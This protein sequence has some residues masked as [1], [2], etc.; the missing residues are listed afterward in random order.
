MIEKYCR[1]EHPD[2]K[3]CARARCSC[4][5]CFDCNLGCA[6]LCHAER[7][8]TN[9]QATVL[10]AAALGPITVDTLRQVAKALREEPS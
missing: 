7:E 6:C 1:C 10:T 8:L 9:L 2:R 4:R 3:G 5:Q